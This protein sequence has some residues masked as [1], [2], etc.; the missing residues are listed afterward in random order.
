MIRCLNETASHLPKLK[1]RALDV[2]APHI[3]GTPHWIL[4]RLMRIIETA[5]APAEFDAKSAGC[6]HVNVDGLTVDVAAGAHTN[7]R[8]AYAQEMIRGHDVIERLHFEH[9]M[10]QPGRFAWHAWRES[11]AVV[12]LVAA[13]EAQTNVVV[14]VDPI[15][16]AKAQHA[17]VETMRALGVCYREQHVA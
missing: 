2:T 5:L 7:G 12:T 17:G 6:L 4:D 1:F 3:D 9:D 15:T 16:Q 13:Q 11:H 8:L 10:L 14:D